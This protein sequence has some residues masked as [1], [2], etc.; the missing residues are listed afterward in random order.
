MTSPTSRGTP[1]RRS[2]S[3]GRTERTR[4]GMT[5]EPGDIVLVPF[6]FTDLTAAKRRPVLVLSSRDFNAGLNDFIVCGITS[7]LANA[8]HSVLIDNKDMAKGRLPAPSRIKVGKIATLLQ[9]LS[10]RTV[11]RVK[12]DVLARARKELFTIL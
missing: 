8:S 10:L 7:N 6:P 2:G 3:S 5:Y 9:S 11:G 4:S 12:A 1:R